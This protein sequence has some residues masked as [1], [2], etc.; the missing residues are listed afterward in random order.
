MEITARSQRKRREE[1][2]LKKKQDEVLPLKALK[3]IRPQNL[4]NY[5]LFF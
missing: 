5:E 1:E 3:N 4:F 2:I